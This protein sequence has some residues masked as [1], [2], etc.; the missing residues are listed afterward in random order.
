MLQPDRRGGSLFLDQRGVL[1]EHLRGALDHV[2]GG[3]VQRSDLVENELLIA[4]RLS[5][6]HGGPQRGDR[7]GGGA[8]DTLDQLDVVLDDDVDRQVALDRDRQ[9]REQVLVLLADVEEHVLVEHLG[10]LRIGEL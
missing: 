4:Q 7:R 9:L 2:A 8:V 10:L 6:D 5:H 1:L 3:R